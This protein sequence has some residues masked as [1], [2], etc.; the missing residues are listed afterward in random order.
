LKNA[1]KKRTVTIRR[2]YLFFEYEFISDLFILLSSSVQ[3]SE[4]GGDGD[5]GN[6]CPDPLQGLV[7]G[8]LSQDEASQLCGH[9]LEKKKLTASRFSQLYSWDNRY[10]GVGSALILYNGDRKNYEDPSC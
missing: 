8:L 9:F 3:N 10:D 2:V 5:G 7:D 6:N 1:H 4:G